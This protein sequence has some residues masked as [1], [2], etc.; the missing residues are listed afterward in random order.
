VGVLRILAEGTPGIW[1]EEDT[2]HAR[3]SLATITPAT[4]GFLGIAM[5]GSAT[6]EPVAYGTSSYHV[7]STFALSSG[8][9]EG[10]YL[11]L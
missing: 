1:L 2:V 7:V 6:N 3:H 5:R 11:D 4:W 9:L 10:T 8:C